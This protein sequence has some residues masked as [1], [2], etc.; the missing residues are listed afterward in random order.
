LAALKTIAEGE[1]EGTEVCEQILADKSRI[2]QLQK[3]VIELE[4]ELEKRKAETTVVHDKN[5]N[6]LKGEDDES[7]AK[8]KEEDLKR[9]VSELEETRGRI[10]ELDL[11][12]VQAEKE[13]L[14]E[15]L[16]KRGKDNKKLS[17]LL[18]QSQIERVKIN[19]HLRLH[20]LQ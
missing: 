19:N 4:S 1:D 7:N 11:K 9:F 20:N 14:V 5:T 16:N 2:K 17:H 12:I 3:R 15:Q 6:S 18:D 13:K 8:N 10:N